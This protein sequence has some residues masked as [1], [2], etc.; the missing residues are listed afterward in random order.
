MSIQSV[1]EQMG[2][3]GITG[4]VVSVKGKLVAQ[5]SKGNQWQRANTN[6]A[7]ALFRNALRLTLLKS[8]ETVVARTGERMVLGTYVGCVGDRFEVCVS[9]NE[10]VFTEHMLPV[11]V[12]VETGAW[13][14]RPNMQVAAYV[15]GEWL[16]GTWQGYAD[17]RHS[18]QL[19]NGDFVSS[20]RAYTAAY[21]VEHGLVQ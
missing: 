5:I 18:V 3:T 7:T 4:R 14:F 12:A 15:E 2:T 17:G 21:A 13:S 9:R 6:Q 20:D 10:H 11:D 8:G 16:A 19:T 1:Y